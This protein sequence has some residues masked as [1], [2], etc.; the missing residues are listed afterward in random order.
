MD[1]RVVAFDLEIEVQIPEDA[2][3]WAPF[4][5]YGI[6]C[7]ATLIS[8]EKLRLWHG[9]RSSNGIYAPRMA[10]EEVRVLA[11]Y[12]YDLYTDGY[13]PLTWNGLG[14]DF[15]VLA[16]ESSSDETTTLCRELALNHIDIAFAMFCAKGFM[17]SL[18][19]AAT[20]MG[21]SGKLDGITGVDAPRLWKRG[22]AGQKKALEYVAQ[23]VRTVA[24][25]YRSIQAKGY[26]RWISRSG[27]PS[28]WPV[29]DGRVPSVSEAVRTPEPDTSWMRDPWPRSRFYGWTGWAPGRK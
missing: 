28:F 3:D 5:P 23:D 27:R 13:L 14:F 22:A 17:V 6:T 12:L 25:L 20:G 18:G 24:D 7:A 8:D 9:P 16:E 2:D 19:K 21:L 26:V 4:R 29:P 15:D 1:R 10:P 11:R